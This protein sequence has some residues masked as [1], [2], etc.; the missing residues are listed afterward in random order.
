[1]LLGKGSVQ[2][3]GAEDSE[4]ALLVARRCSVWWGDQTGDPVILFR[5]AQPSQLSPNGVSHPMT[6]LH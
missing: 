1:M 3:L 5:E 4:L 6:P 2:A